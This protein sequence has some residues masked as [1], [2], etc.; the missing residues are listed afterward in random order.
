MARE[1]DYQGS[2]EE[3]LVY[4]Y[5]YIHYLDKLF[6]GGKLCEERMCSGNPNNLRNISLR[7]S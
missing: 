3:N 1:R 6:E 4:I 2:I 7:F 5:I